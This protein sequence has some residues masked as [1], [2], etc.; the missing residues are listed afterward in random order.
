[1]GLTMNEML[2][3][4]ATLVEEGSSLAGIAEELGVSVKWLEQVMGTDGYKVVKEAVED[5]RI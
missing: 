2:V 4:I 3:A 1:M 5:G